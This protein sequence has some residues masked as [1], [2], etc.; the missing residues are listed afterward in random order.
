MR[1]KIM[2]GGTEQPKGWPGST[3]SGS[4]KL[5]SAHRQFRDWSLYGGDVFTIVENFPS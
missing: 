3:M 4:S 2:V 5:R 1:T